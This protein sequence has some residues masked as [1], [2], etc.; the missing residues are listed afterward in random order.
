MNDNIRKLLK[1]TLAIVANNKQ[2]LM[3][4]SYEWSVIFQRHSVRDRE[5]LIIKPERIVLGESTATI[6]I[7]LELPVLPLDLMC[8]YG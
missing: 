5:E 4:A 3:E 8:Q 7:I 2:E 6:Y 1:D